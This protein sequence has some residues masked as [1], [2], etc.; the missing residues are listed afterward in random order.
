MNQLKILI[1]ILL[2][3]L[4]L[5][6]AAETED[7]Y[8]P[9]LA[10]YP[11]ISYS[12][13]TGFIF[14]AIA[15]YQFYS[16]SITDPFFRNKLQLQAVYT[17]RH[18]FEFNFEPEFYRD[19]GRTRIAGEIKIRNWPSDYYGIGSEAFEDPES[20]TRKG[21]SLKL[22]FDREIVE[23]IYLGFTSEYDRADITD[24]SQNC[25]LVINQIPGSCNYQ[26]FG[27]GGS[28]IRDKRNSRNYPTRGNYQ[29]LKILHY[30]KKLGSDF[31]FSKA[32]IDLRYYFSID[33]FNTFAIQNLLEF[34]HKQA[35]FLELAELGD[36]MRAFDSARFID[37][38]LFLARIEY[39]TFPLQIKLLDRLGFVVFAETGNVADSYQN[40]NI[41]ELKFCYGGGL[42]FSIFTDDRT[43]L[44]FDLGFSEG[45]TGINIG[46][47]EAF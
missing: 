7:P 20:Y 33:T 39:R 8:K 34:T 42:R 30:D 14:G 46:F 32:Y 24:K 26:I 6:L 27:L 47:A 18:Q 23:R 25:S 37:N 35:P 9:D 36:Q 13:E 40:L 17:E 11:Q 1:L 4:P 22:E 15:L 29:Q 2:I 5:I 28:L 12:N 44:R 31:Q 43:N 10:A 3:L 38:H 41:S 45:E 19:K 21:F 16:A